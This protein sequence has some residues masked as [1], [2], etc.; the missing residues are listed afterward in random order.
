MLRSFQ[1]NGHTIGFYPQTADI[2][3]FADIVLRIGISEGEKARLLRLRRRNRLKL[4]KGSVTINST[5]S[6]NNNVNVREGK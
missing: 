6:D 3:L 5:D 1:F 4:I 2:Q